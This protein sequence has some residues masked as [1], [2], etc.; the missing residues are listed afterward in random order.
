ML[1]ATVRAN[2]K[3]TFCIIPICNHTCSLTGLGLRN[4]V[5]GG[6]YLETNGGENGK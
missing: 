5:W 3:D 4:K 1:P 6:A 2:G